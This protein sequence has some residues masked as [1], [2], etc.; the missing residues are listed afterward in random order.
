MISK[1]NTYLPYLLEPFE[2]TNIFF[3][4]YVIFEAQLSPF[5]Y[6]LTG[7][8]SFLKCSLLTSC[9]LNSFESILS[10]RF[11]AQHHYPKTANLKNRIVL[12][13][14]ENQRRIQSCIINIVNSILYI[15]IFCYQQNDK[16]RCPKR[17]RF[18]FFFEQLTKE[19]DSQERNHKNKYLLVQRTNG[20]YSALMQQVHIFTCYFL[21]PLIRTSMTVSHLLKLQS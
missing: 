8:F 14:Q 6:F 7:F 2:E 12:N 5:M 4:S 15:S 21:T 17:K 16:L 13:E 19:I 9:Y 1:Q 11:L 3:W 20:F 18:I 10:F